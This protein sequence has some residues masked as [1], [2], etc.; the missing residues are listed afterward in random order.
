MKLKI[1]LFLV[2][3]LLSCAC[4][5]RFTYTFDLWSVNTFLYST[6]SIQTSFRTIMRRY[7]LTSF[8]PLL[9][10]RPPLP[11]PHHHLYI[12]L[13]KMIFVCRLQNE[14]CTLVVFCT[15][16]NVTKKDN[17]LVLFFQEDADDFFS[18]SNIFSHALYFMRVPINYIYFYQ[19]IFDIYCEQF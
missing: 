6:R 16:D 5:T 13:K 4:S 12:T 14:I 3:N 7:L 19:T 17:F 10:P 15:S 18:I 8:P 11:L 9:T 1:Y 2:S